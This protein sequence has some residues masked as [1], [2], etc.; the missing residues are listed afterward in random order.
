MTKQSFKTPTAVAVIAALAALI[1][2]RSYSDEPVETVAAPQAPTSTAPF[3]PRASAEFVNQLS[4]AESLDVAEQTL[5]LAL[6]IDEIPSDNVERLAACYYN[7]LLLDAVRAGG[8]AAF[9]G[10]AQR[11]LDDARRYDVC[12]NVA[13]QACRNLGAYDSERAKQ[14]YLA[15]VGDLAASDQP[16]RRAASQRVLN[17]ARF[18]VDAASDST[19]DFSGFQYV[20]GS[21][22]EAAR[23]L[24]ALTALYDAGRRALTLRSLTQLV[25]FEDQT[26]FADY[27]ATR[28]PYDRA[29]RDT[30]FAPAG[31]RLPSD[32]S[33]TLARVRQ[34]LGEKNP[35]VML[36]LIAQFKKEA[37][38]IAFKSH[39]PRCY[40]NYFTALGLQASQVGTDEAFEKLV[41]Q[42]VSTV[43]SDPETTDVVAM[44]IARDLK[45]YDERW[46][47]R[48]IEK[49]KESDD[50]KTNDVA[51]RVEGEFR[52][53]EGRGFPAALEGVCE[54][55]DHITFDDYRGKRVLLCL[56]HNPI[57]PDGTF[58]LVEKYLAE[59]LEVV[60][61]NGYN[62]RNA[63]VATDKFKQISRVRTRANPELGG[64]RYVDLM[65]YYGLGFYSGSQVALI[66]ADGS[67]VAMGNSVENIM[68][69]L[70]SLFPEV[71]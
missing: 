48:L 23:R 63:F 42:Y 8:D 12:A 65:D 46:F 31:F 13:F 21:A 22:E 60:L 62:R 18:N 70:K 34:I 36:D 68:D 56:N 44:E 69:D 19:L 41:E 51:V 3:D 7:L 24:A 43:E 67:V 58:P 49:L 55:G 28:A 11:V 47:L 64:R 10:Y 27:Y 53:A 54:D 5:E 59:G 14:L 30:P 25:P 29:L 26:A 37:S 39:A 17:N 52:K 45:R 71:E 57:Q 20:D 16:L 32:D 2:Q 35:D 6:T 1:A 33:E 66:G 4:R 50:P 15:L 38:E 40:K 9:D 61:Y